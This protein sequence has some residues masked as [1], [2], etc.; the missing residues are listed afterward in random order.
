M[1]DEKYPLREFWENGFC[2]VR[3]VFDPNI[4]QAWKAHGEGHANRDMFVHD[5]L[6]ELI[7]SPSATS[8]ARAI[9]E[10]HELIYFGDSNP[11][12]GKTDP[13]FHKDNADKDDGNAPDWRGRYPIIRFGLY[14]GDHV[15]RSGCLDLREGSHLT[16]S[17]TQGRHVAAKTQPGDLV[18]WNLRTSHSGGSMLLRTGTAL[19]PSSVI[20][21]IA[22]RMPLGMVAPAYSNRIGLFWTYALAGAHLD[23]YIAYLKTRRY[24][25]DR[26]LDT[27]YRPE[28]IEEAAVAGVAV[29]DVRRE[30]VPGSLGPVHDSHVALAY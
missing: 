12:V 29:R 26:W 11:I 22:R 6:R 5:R 15:T 23:R 21:K 8:C 27:E 28:W 2:I 19:D 7:L 1:G 3:Q 14:T 20:G 25:V 13:G 17:V 16:V 10:T 4:V 30:F 9:L 18:I 24:A